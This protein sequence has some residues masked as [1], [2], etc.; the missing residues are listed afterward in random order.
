MCVTT[1]VCYQKCVLPQMCYQKCV[2]TNVCYQ[3]CVTTNVLW[4]MCVTKNVCYHKCVA[5]AIFV[6]A[7]PPFW[8]PPG[9]IPRIVFAIQQACCN[10][11]DLKSSRIL[12]S[13][14]DESTAS[15]RNVCIG[16]S[17]RLPFH[18]DCCVP[19]PLIQKPQELGGPAPRWAAAP[20]RRKSAG[21]V[22]VFELE[23]MKS[24]T[25]TRRG[26][27]EE[28]TYIHLF[29]SWTLLRCEW[30]SSRSG[31]FIPPHGKGPR[32]WLIVGLVGFRTGVDVSE[33]RRSLVVARNREICMKYLSR[34]TMC[35]CYSGQALGVVPFV[36]TKLPISA[37]VSHRHL[38]SHRN[39]LCFEADVDVK[40]FFPLFH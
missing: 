6:T 20:E 28:V 22:N 14:G 24:R 21:N 32:Y 36:V 38:S 27:V 31:R 40:C 30:P 25:C 18:T 17:T 33:E 8:E 19:S 37:T 16:Q 5:V 12:C 39:R 23:M 2:T 4:K 35:V 10:S 26:G 9:L 3:K 11:E 15:C 29:L 1:N 13:G 34:R 7:R